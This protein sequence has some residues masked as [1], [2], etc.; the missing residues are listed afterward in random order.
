MANGNVKG[1]KVQSCV[2]QW[3]QYISHDLFGNKNTESALILSHSILHGCS[4]KVVYRYGVASK[5]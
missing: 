5:S 4:F 1:M 2:Q 3:P